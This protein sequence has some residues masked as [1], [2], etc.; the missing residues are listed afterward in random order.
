MSFSSVNYAEECL[1]KHP[2]QRF[3]AREIAEWILKNY[4]EE[5]KKK[6]IKSTLD[7]SNDDKL[8]AQ[9]AGEITSAESRDRFSG[10]F[11]GIETETEANRPRL[12]YWIEKSG[13]AKVKLSEHDLYPLLAQYLFTE[14]NIYS[15]RINERKS[16]HHGKNGNKWLHPD[17]VGLE[18]LSQEWD[19]E[20]K[21][22]AIKMS[23]STICLS[24]YEVKIELNSANVREA[25]FQAVSNSSW[26]NFG[27]LVTTRI[28]NNKIETELR[29]LSNLHGIG[30]ILLNPETPA[31][32]QIMI[33]SVEHNIDW[34]TINRIARENP[35][36]LEYIRC[37]RETVTIGR[38]KASDW[39][40]ITDENN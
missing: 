28:N 18:Y 10:Y 14:L 36:F 23:A 33:P 4:P 27:Y 8:R 21:Q 11:A 17:L 30:V 3:T 38:I 24:A 22:C 31:Q 37:V 29:L 35:D 2:G 15:K 12:F 6:R 7:L 39:Y 20:I 26:A 25:F 16:I 5:C 1:K 9:I 34:D 19:N 32:S 13:F 40:K